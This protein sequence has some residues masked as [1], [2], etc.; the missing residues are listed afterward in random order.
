M[1]SR[2]K[3]IDATLGLIAD[4]GFRGVS[5]AS[6]ALAAGVSR[7]T[8]Y[9]VFGT[10]EDL[11]SQSMIALASEVFAEI[12]QSLESIGDPAEFVVELIVVARTTVRAHPVLATLLRGDAD[13]PLNEDDV[14][15][16]AKP[17][18]YEI[19]SPMKA[20]HPDIEPM[21][22]DIL[23]MGVRLALSVILFDDATIRADDDLRRFLFRWLAPALPRKP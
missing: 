15:E 4:E 12:R 9:S 22:D 5:I 14:I 7:Q 6:V 3:I 13:N 23:Q 18:A 20:M 16:R 21:M 17:I 8:V 2:A 11:V 19:L 10:R 1:R